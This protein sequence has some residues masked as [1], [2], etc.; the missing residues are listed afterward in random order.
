MV[1]LPCE[2]LDATLIDLIQQMIFCTQ[3]NCKLFLQ[4][5]FDYAFSNTQP[6]RMILCTRNRQRVSLLC[7][8]KDDLQELLTWKRI[9]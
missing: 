8:L 7:A 3:N 1:F 2:F 5:A 9:F 4:C 6:V